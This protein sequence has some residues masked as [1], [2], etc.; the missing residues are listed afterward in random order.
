MGYVPGYK[1]DIFVS[2]AHFDNETDSQDVRWVSRFQLDLRNALRQ[3]LGQEPDVFFDTRNFEAHEHTD[4]LLEN[5]R[6]SAVFVVIFSPSYVSRE[7]TIGELKAFHEN[8]PDV[9][10]IVT[11]ELLPVD[12]DLIHPLLSGR[13]RTPFWWKDA[14]EQDI[15]LRLTPKFN[16]EIY[17]TRL[18]I[19]AHQVKRL[20][21][22]LRAGRSTA[23]DEVGDAPEA[24]AAAPR[25]ADPVAPAGRT[26]LLAQATDDLYDEREQVRAYLEQFGVKVVP[27]ND[28][29][30]GGADFAAA[31]AAELGNAGIFVQL[32]GSFAARRPPDLAQGYAAYQFEAAAARGLKILQWRR[33]DLDLAAVTHRDK[34]LLEGPDVLAVGLEEFKG[35]ILRRA[36]AAAK[37]EP[38][39][40]GD[41]HFFINADRSD[42]ELADRL[43]K[44][45]ENNAQ[46]SAARPLFEGSA[47]D[48]TDDLEANLLNCG[49]LL[50]LY[51]NAPPAWVRAQLLRWSK[52]ER[53]REE[54]LRLKTIVLGPP[55]PKPEIAWAGGFQ[56][57]DGQDG[58]IEQRVRDILEGLRA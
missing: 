2:Y 21:A 1:H 43:L 58:S 11:V 30:Q 54:P 16:P 29:P 36:T 20:L 33:P 44:L 23:A 4:R 57:I 6:A 24:P 35:E 55:A 12:E 46:W 26:V 48:V 42:K 5:A 32:L 56:R 45:F 41:C 53:L 18:Q 39:Q 38:Q 17:N 22:D 51:G 10:R 8:A 34:A 15:P 50:L 9:A 47:K 37:P 14:A 3:R 49:V 28:F 7:F 19:L 31:F 25:P 52:L 13:K 27:E 40:V